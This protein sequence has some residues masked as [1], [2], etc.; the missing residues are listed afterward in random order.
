MARHDGSYGA[1]RL[2]LQTLA[3]HRM[4]VSQKLEGVWQV[5]TYV[6]STRTFVIGGEFEAAG[7]WLP[8]D[9]IRYVDEATGT[10][11]T[12]RYGSE[13]WIAFAAVPGPD[14]RFIVFV[15]ESR[16]DGAFEVGPFRLQVL[17]TTKDALY[18]LGRPPAPPPPSEDDAFEYDPADGWDWGTPVGGLVQMD[19]G[20]ITFSD[21]RTIR[22]SYGA[23]TIKRRAGRR[24]QRSWDLERTVARGRMIPPPAEA[25][26]TP[27]TPIGGLAKDSLSP[28]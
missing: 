19:P 24:H 4:V 8:L 15:G 2:E 1:A 18:D 25:P 11:R 13:T 20:I 28:R 26:T 23:D 5:L 16:A 9:E 12:S 21:A 7:S 6:P 27:A 10:M 17:D 3:D 14:G 22:V